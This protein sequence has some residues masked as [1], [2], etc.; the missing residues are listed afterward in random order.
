LKRDL[1][2][3]TGGYMEQDRAQAAHM[4]AA[5]APTLCTLAFD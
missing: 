5:I 2:L 3:Q 4:D 1:Q